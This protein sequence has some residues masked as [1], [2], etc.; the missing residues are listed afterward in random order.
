MTT[1]MIQRRGLASQWTAINPILEIGELGFEE[2]TKKF[3]IGDGQSTWNILPYFVNETSIPDVQALLATVN[4]QVQSAIQT[5]VSTAVAGLVDSAPASLNTLNELAAAIADDSTF[6]NTITTAL[7]NKADS[8]HSH[9]LD[10]L[11][12]V[13]VASATTGQVLQKQ[14][15]GTWSAT[16]LSSAAVSY[17]DL[18]NVPT[19]FTPSAHT[20]TDVEISHVV[21]TE[22]GTSYT[23]L[24]AD[25]EKTIRFTSATAVAFTVANVLSP[26]Q[27]VDIYQKG[28]GTITFTPGSGVT[29]EA[30]G[31]SGGNFAI[32]NKFSA[33]TIMCD[34][35][36]VYA[37]VGSVEIA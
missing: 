36:G 20:H 12:D 28:A 24:A 27:R 2:D 14:S 26:G 29:L 6:A 19:S 33:A 23:L 22:T 8:T 4:Q 21:K 3:K 5:S 9:T 1:R 18:T 34:S 31:V 25:A 17:N 11:S 13:S 16:S 32:V 15:N 30:V 7:A 37:I 10:D 35:A